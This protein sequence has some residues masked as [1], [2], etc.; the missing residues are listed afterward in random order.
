MKIS[1][2]LVLTAALSLTTVAP[3][4][5]DLWYNGNFDG[6]NA[7]SNERNTS[8]SQ[9]NVYDDFIVPA[10][11]QWDITSVFSNDLMSFTGVTSAYWE[12]RSGVSLGNGGTLVASG[13]GTA[14]QTPTG[15][16]AFGLTEYTI[17]VAGLNVL[18]NSGTYW[19]TV[20]PIDSGGGRSF[21]S[22]TSGAG[23]VG[24]P[25][26]NNGNS[27]WNSSEFGKNFGLPSD[28]LGSGTWD[29][30]EGVSG[31][32]VSGVPEPSSIILLVTMFAGLIVTIR[33][34][35]AIPT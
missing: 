7:L 21:V 5:A 22:T 27:F 25:P 9:S 2:L 1:S 6:R 29:F 17:D 3:L 26:G 33:K 34:R 20:S 23:A 31:S 18:L 8:V 14:T 28:S 10:A 13:T 4:R 35:F 30:S 24:T 12:I 19:L 15:R 16:S 32:V 11:Q